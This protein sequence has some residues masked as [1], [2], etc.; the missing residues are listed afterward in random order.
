MDEWVASESPSADSGSTSLGKYPLFPEMTVVLMR[1]ANEQNANRRYC[2]RFLFFK[3]I[4]L[5]GKQ[6]KFHYAVSK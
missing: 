3:K 5:E 1:T 6:N 2:M 4:T